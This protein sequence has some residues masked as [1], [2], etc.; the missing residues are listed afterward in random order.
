MVHFCYLAVM[1]ARWSTLSDYIGA[2]SEVHALMCTGLNKRQE[3]FYI[4]FCAAND[5]GNDF[6]IFSVC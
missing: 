5:D 3:Q 4:T 1:S 6:N 2:D